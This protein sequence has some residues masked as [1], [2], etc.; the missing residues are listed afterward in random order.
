MVSDRR[1][2]A[3]EQQQSNGGDG[4]A[5]MASENQCPSG[6]MRGSLRGEAATAYSQYI[7]RPPQQAARASL[8]PIRMAANPGAAPIQTI[9]PNTFT[10]ILNV[11]EAQSHLSS[12]SATGSSGSLPEYIDRWVC[13]FDEVNI[14]GYSVLAFRESKLK[15]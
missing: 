4:L 12:R 2:A 1:R 15:G 9:I 5:A 8:P 6:R 7:L 14:V 13:T 10:P 11:S 3:R